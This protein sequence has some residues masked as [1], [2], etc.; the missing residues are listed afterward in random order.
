MQTNRN[1]GYSNEMYLIPAI[2]FNYIIIYIAVNYYLKN[3]MYVCVFI[4][5]Q[6]NK[7]LTSKIIT[8]TAL[9]R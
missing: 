2:R 1:V 8:N 5:L 9:D 7:L 4:K 3:K 6:L